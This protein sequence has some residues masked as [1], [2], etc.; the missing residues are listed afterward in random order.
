MPI[1]TVNELVTYDSRYA[2]LLWYIRLL[3]NM[4][5]NSLDNFLPIFIVGNSRS[6]TT[7]VSRI[8]GNSP[9]VFTFEE[10]HFFEELWSPSSE[11]DHMSE[12]EA[13]ELIAQLL[14]IQ[15]N[16]Y[17]TQTKPEEYAQEAQEVIHKLQQTE[18]PSFLFAAFLQYESNLNG[19][20]RPCE[21]TP[22][23][24]LYIHEIC[25][26]YPEAR[27]I[28]II[29]DPRDVLLSQKK[30]WKRFVNSKRIPKR[31][32]LRA[33]MNY[34]PFT[35]SK[36]WNANILAAERF[37]ENKQVLFIRFEDLLED[38]EQTVQRI[39]DFVDIDFD[40]HLLDVPQVGSSSEPDQPNRKGI[41]KSRVEGWRKGDLS[42][43]E[44][45]IC[46][47]NNKE[48]MDKY[49]YT[50]EPVSLN[51][52]ALISSFIFFPIKL[53]LAL[54]LSLNRMRNIGDSIRRRLA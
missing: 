50:I 35:I 30:K 49:G 12:E 45:F 52:M 18:S 6:G 54:L 41:N 20:Q 47:S 19:K 24:V 4:I 17:L 46:Q 26:I 43:T 2:K 23:N 11:L 27:I 21:Q 15:R 33:W 5:L 36:L 44:V 22:R 1:V 9:S 14:C 40:T 39:C 29:R 10:L 34:H 16:C 42:P 32:V 48:L 31:E 3:L 28:N 25:E 8:L 38:P 51:V 13:I 7:L 53:T 37:V